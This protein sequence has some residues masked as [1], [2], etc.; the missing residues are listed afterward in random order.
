MR[1]DATTLAMCVTIL[2]WLK[3]LDEEA[4]FALQ[5]WQTSS[6][7]NAVYGFTYRLEGNGDCRRTGVNTQSGHTRLGSWENAVDIDHLRCAI[8]RSVNF[9][10]PRSVTGVLTDLIG[11]RRRSVGHIGDCRH[12]DRCNRAGYTLDAKLR[13]CGAGNTRKR[14][15][16]AE[17]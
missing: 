10:S 12:G 16:V 4:G 13:G 17:I 15:E 3:M 7:I 14:I 5:R 6:S 2:R 11:Q 8:G 1:L 9:R